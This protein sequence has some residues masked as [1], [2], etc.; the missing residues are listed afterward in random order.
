M[1]NPLG[2]IDPEG[3]SQP[4]EK[5]DDSAA[6]QFEPNLFEG[7]EGKLGDDKPQP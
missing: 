2:Q 3:V 4:I 7:K 6:G 5:P 1:D